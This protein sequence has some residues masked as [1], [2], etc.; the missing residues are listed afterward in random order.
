[1]N[2]GGENTGARVTGGADESRGE[3]TSTRLDYVVP[4]GESSI[5]LVPSAS[6]MRHP[7][8]RRNRLRRASWKLVLRRSWNDFISDALMDRAAVLAFFMFRTAAPTVLAAYS[9]ATLIFARNREQVTDLTQEAIGKYVP[10]EI[11]DEVRSVVEV[12]VGS[13]AGGTR[14]LILAVVI[15]LFS[16]SAWVR[17]FSRS[18]NFIYGRVEGRSILSTWVTMWG[19]TVVMVVGAVTIIG[20][21]LLRES[22]V[23][24]VFEPIAHPLGLVDELNFLTSIF[25]PIWRWIR[26]PVV[27]V[28][29]LTL[30]AVLYYFAPNVRPR[31]F[32]W[33]TLG[34]AVAV[35]C[36]GITWW[37]LGMYLRYFA[38]ASA[39]GA[40]GTLIAVI[41]ACWVMN[42][43]LV[44]G[45]KLDAE[46]L[47]AKELQV[48]YNSERHI[49]APSRATVAARK[50]VHNQSTLEQQARE[51]K[52]TSS[53]D[54]SHPE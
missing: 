43:I 8:D 3:S 14:A 11:A 12:I 41:I 36:V 47:R 50:Y 39:Y 5:H 51:L 40:I 44:V 15:G 42:I 7:L 20:A 6:G 27:L 10:G 28:I 38:G 35:C 22:V 46:V 48:G 19:I 13:A 25:L 9:I 49:Q 16:S 26:V 21:S 32:R 54:E 24:A 52:R 45:V 31:R 34:S 37:L 18:A 33:L 1:M 4:T 29:A 2:A 30:V 23:L 53:K 17:A